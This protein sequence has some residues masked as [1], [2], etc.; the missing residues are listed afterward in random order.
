MHSPCQLLPLIYC[1]SQSPRLQYEAKAAKQKLF[2]K[3]HDPLNNGR[4]SLSELTRKNLTSIHPMVLKSN[5]LQYKSRKS[6]APVAGTS[7]LIV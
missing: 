3:G 1:L 4:K 7:S 2:L 6:L 5:L